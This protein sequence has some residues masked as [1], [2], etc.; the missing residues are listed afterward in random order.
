MFPSERWKRSIDRHKVQNYT[1]VVLFRNFSLFNKTLVSHERSRFQADVL[2]W[3]FWLH[4]CVKSNACFFARGV[5][6]FDVRV[7]MSSVQVCAGGK[8]YISV[9][10]T[11]CLLQCHLSFAQFLCPF[12]FSHYC[13]L[14]L[15][16]L[17]YPETFL[18]IFFLYLRPHIKTWPLSSQRGDRPGSAL[19]LHCRTAAPVR[20]NRYK[21]TPSWIYDTPSVCLLLK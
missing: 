12:I 9:S 16:K 13:H 6:L 15:C 1:P 5:K 7:K 3:F 20:N 18:F 2:T 8:W 10:V 11:P 4:I 17:Q 14:V 21:N 19:W